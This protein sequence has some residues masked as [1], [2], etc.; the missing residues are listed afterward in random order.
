MSNS[1]VVTTEEELRVACEKKVEHILIKGDLAKTVEKNMK[2]R[3][4]RKKFMIGSVAIAGLGFIAAPFTGGASIPIAGLLA[5]AEEGGAV[6]G[7]AVS[8]IAIL[9]AGGLGLSIITVLA[10]YELEYSTSDGTSIKLKPS[11]S[12]EK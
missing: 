8:T 3:K 11:N 1:V 12:K 2:Q 6:G 9:L 10:G 7:A 4:T 5:A